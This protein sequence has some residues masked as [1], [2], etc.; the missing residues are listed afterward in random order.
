[1]FVFSR[2]ES[3]KRV[4]LSVDE[5][6]QNVFTLIENPFHTPPPDNPP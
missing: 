4:P 6:K 2:Q 1:M 3:G 5:L